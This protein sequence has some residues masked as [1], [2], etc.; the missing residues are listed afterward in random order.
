MSL[1]LPRKAETSSPSLVILCWNQTVI[2]AH[3]AGVS[4]SV[5]CVTWPL[6]LCDTSHR[7]IRSP[8]STGACGLL[9]SLCVRTGSEA[10][11]LHSVSIC[12]LSLMIL[13]VLESPGAISKPPLLLIALWTLYGRESLK[14]K[15]SIWKQGHSSL[16]THSEL[17]HI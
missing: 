7:V 1:C 3:N 5:V 8:P 9:L 17:S 12:G 10:Q 11:S 13:T 16:M 15:D 14:K 6:G 4:S 2:S